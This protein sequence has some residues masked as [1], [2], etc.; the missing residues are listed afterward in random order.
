MVSGLKRSEVEHRVQSRF[1]GGGGE[2]VEAF[3][4]C[5]VLGLGFGVYAGFRA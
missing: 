5:R 3:S 2:G 1:S 4:W